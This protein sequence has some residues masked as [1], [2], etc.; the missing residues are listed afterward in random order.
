MAE[1]RALLLSPESPYPPHGGGALRT[2]SIHEYL[3]SRYT[4][5]LIVFATPEGPEPPFASAVIRVPCHSRSPG[6]RAA[7]NLGRFLRGTPPLMDRFA[8]FHR[9]LSRAIGDTHYDVAILEHFWTAPYL[10]TVASHGSRILL[11]LHNI[12]SVWLERIGNTAPRGLKLPF[13]RWAANCRR[14]ERELLP[15][16]ERIL[17]ASEE[18]AETV[19]SLAPG[20]RTLV[21]PNAIPRV[22]EPVSERRNAI[23]F[24]GNLEYQPN[25]QAVQFFARRIWP[26]LATEFPDLEWHLI[27]RNPRGVQDSVFSSPRVRVIGP[28]EDAVLELSR[29]R[30]AV[31]PVLSGSGTRL[32]IIEAWAAGVPVV[33]TP[34][35][36][37]GLAA[38]PDCH[39]LTASDPDAFA[40]AVSRLLRDPSLSQSVAAA[41][42][43][44]YEE[45]FS[46]DVAWNT[47]IGNGI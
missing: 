44:L 15:R 47:F 2:A 27:G 33:S 35:G 17:V 43:R 7:R 32:K 11:D 10:D 36:A 16:F 19:R 30:V 40:R 41:G 9:Q 24:S 1:P 42:R 6:V 29:Y 34:L 8:G 38:S 20:A 26:I 5:D 18:D 23:V 14:L 21:Y 4:V 25:R 46:W 13:R 3:R 31:V 39:L 22:P 45:R 12:E 28:I 37:E